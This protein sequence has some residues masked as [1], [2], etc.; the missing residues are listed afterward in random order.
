MAKNS[1][2]GY[3]NGSVDDRTQFHNPHNN[4]WNKRDAE[5]GRIMGVKQDTPF[6]GVAKEEDGRRN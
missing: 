6:K 1:G 3:R 5:T 2:N 4:T